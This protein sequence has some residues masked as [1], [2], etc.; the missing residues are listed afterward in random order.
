[1]GKRSS[2]AIDVPRRHPF[3]P[4][5]TYDEFDRLWEKI[6]SQDTL[7]LGFRTRERDRM[8]EDGKKSVPK[9]RANSKGLDW[10]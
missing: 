7:A 6:G 9:H 3:C 10:P 4:A 2:Y 1:M 8:L 5:L